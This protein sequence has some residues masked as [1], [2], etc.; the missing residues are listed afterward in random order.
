MHERLEENASA[1]PP[2]ADE[3][4]ERVEIDGR[5]RKSVTEKNLSR[6]QDW[7]LMHTPLHFNELFRGQWH[8]DWLWTIQMTFNLL[9]RRINESTETQPFTLHFQGMFSAEQL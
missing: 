1:I 7:V 5:S 3:Y 2:E 8:R 6:I 4:Q 9:E